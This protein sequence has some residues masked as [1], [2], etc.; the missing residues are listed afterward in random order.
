MKAT[1]FSR[2]TLLGLVSLSL[3][4]VLFVSSIFLQGTT[5]ALAASHPL[6]KFSHLPVGPQSHAHSVTLPKGS[7]P[8]KGKGGSFKWQSPQ[9]CGFQD[10]TPVVVGSLIYVASYCG[11]IYALNASDGSTA[12]SN[13]LG[14]GFYSTVTVVSGVVYSADNCNQ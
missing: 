4:T 13:S 8:F 3:F 1:K 14:C 6:P 11:T 12:W 7:S 2:L 10:S 9:L 5:S